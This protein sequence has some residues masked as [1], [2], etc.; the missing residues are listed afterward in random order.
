MKW[1]IKGLKG[2][3]K[4]DKLET[5]LKEKLRGSNSGNKREAYKGKNDKWLTN[6]FP[7]CLFVSCIQFDRHDFFHN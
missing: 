1:I 5:H 2:E 4:Q 6:H 3:K 7:F